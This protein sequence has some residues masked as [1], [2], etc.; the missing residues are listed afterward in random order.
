MSTVIRSWTELLARHRAGAELPQGV[1]ALLGSGDDKKAEEVLRRAKEHR[2]R[3]NEER[4]LRD[5]FFIQRQAEK[6]KEQELLDV[7][8]EAKLQAWISKKEEEIRQRKREKDRIYFE[9]IQRDAERERQ[10]QEAMNELKLHLK[11]NLRSRSHH[12]SVRSVSARNHSDDEDEESVGI[13]FE[14]PSVTQYVH[15][16]V[17]R[18]VHLHE[19]TPVSAQSRKVVEKTSEEYFSSS[20]HRLDPHGK[21][22]SLPPIV[23]EKLQ[24]YMQNTKT[25]KKH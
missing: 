11:E 3:R 5:E 21:S 20:L 6:A 23:A 16:H 24:P 7:D 13:S 15:R 10:R 2:Q 18:H 14:P 22:C 12:S 25:I 17:H 4:R 1:D 19:G 9:T 8:R